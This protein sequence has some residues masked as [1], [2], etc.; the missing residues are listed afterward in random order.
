L[1]QAGA[2][3]VLPSTATVL[4]ALVQALSSERPGPLSAP[5]PPAP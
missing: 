4:T 5:L 1:I 3:A 2:D